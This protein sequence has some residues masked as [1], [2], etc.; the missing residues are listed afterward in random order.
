MRQMRQMLQSTSI[1]DMGT[2]MA[3]K[4][5]SPARP[6]QKGGGSV[7]KSTPTAKAKPAPPSNSPAWQQLSWAD[8]DYGTYWVNAGTLAKVEA[9]KSANA[10]K[11]A[12]TPAQ[13]AITKE[14]ERIVRKVVVKELH[15]QL[16]ELKEFVVAVCRE[17]AV[18]HEGHSIAPQATRAAEEFDSPEVL[19][20]LGGQER[21]PQSADDQLRQLNAARQAVHEFSPHAADTIASMAALRAELAHGDMLSAPEFGK[22]LNL[23]RQQVHKRASARKLL[24]LTIG[25]HGARYPKWQAEAKVLAA[26]PKLLDVAHDAD[27]WDLYAFLLS[28]YPRFGGLSPL[29]ALQRGQHDEVIS[30]AQEFF[31][32][33]A[34]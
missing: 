29:A 25:R 34:S 19:P 31:S 30:F 20:V 8:L 16:V 10:A 33:E 6:S 1:R 32:L 13:E 27:P 4:A 18:S 2:H 14:V 9:E 11:R 28:T 22:L 21:G 15:G 7:R 3:K 12:A 24:A 23:S 5:P 26:M 17:L